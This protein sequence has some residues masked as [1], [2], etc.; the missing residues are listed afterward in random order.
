MTNEEFVSVELARLRGVVEALRGGAVGAHRPFGEAAGR[1][2]VIVRERL[3]AVR[4]AVVHDGGA[5]NGRVAAAVDAEGRVVP[6]HELD[7]LPVTMEPARRAQPGDVTFRGRSIRV[8]YAAGTEHGWLEFTFREVRSDLAHHERQLVVAM[9]R[10][11]G[12]EL[13]R[14]A[15]E[16][17]RLDRMLDPD[18]PNPLRLS[19]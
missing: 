17:L 4:A 1:L 2:L 13:Q 10:W 7:P 11:T 18:R 8:D 19:A 12:K 14:R 16:R 6:V 5:G 15:E 9:A 3:D